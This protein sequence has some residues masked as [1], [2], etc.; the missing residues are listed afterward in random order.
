MAKQIKK[1]QSKKVSRVVP[2]GRLYVSAT[3]NNTL[4][5]ITD[6]QGAVLCWSST[7]EA[8][9]SGSRKSTPYAATVALENAINKAKNYGMSKMDVYIK[10]PGPGRDVALRVLRAQGIKVSMIADLTPVPHNGTRPR[11]ARH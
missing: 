9:F 3:F 6:E 8:G 7:G 5:S 10:G 1:N 4:V 11:K 2:S